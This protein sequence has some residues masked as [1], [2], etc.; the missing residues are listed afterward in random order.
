[1]SLWLGDY[2]K[3]R[4]EIHY[5]EFKLTDNQ[6]S[7]EEYEETKIQLNDRLQR[8]GEFK[9]ILNNFEDVENRIL[10]LK[11]IEGMTL[12]KIAMEIGYSPNYIRNQHAKIMVVLSKFEK[13]YME[14]ELFKK[15]FPYKKRNEV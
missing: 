12:D 7:S 9:I 13:F 10:K 8:E 2:L 15:N 1:M 5:L 6:L 4:N 3:L 11:Y 14:L